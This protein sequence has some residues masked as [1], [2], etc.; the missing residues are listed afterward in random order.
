MNVV[1]PKKEHNETFNYLIP[2]RKKPKKTY[3][4]TYYTRIRLKTYLQKKKKIMN[5]LII[6]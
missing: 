1:E 5:M 2:I 6:R 4:H 3:H